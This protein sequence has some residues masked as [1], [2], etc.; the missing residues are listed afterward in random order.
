MFQASPGCRLIAGFPY[1]RRDNPLK[2]FSLSTF[3]LAG[4]AV[5]TIRSLD[6]VK[7]FSVRGTAFEAAAVG[8]GSTSSEQGKYL[9]PLFLSCEKMTKKIRKCSFLAV[10]LRSFQR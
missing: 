5:S 8:S 3:C 2:D 1:A 9:S 7:V 4:N 10:K 6:P